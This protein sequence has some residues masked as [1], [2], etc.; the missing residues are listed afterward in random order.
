MYSTNLFQKHTFLVFCCW[1]FHIYERKHNHSDYADGLRGWN[2]HPIGLV[3]LTWERSVCFGM[4]SLKNC[5]KGKTSVNSFH[6]PA[7]CRRR[8]LFASENIKFGTFCAS[9][10]SSQGTSGLLTMERA[11][12][13]ISFGRGNCAQHT[14]VA[15]LC[16]AK[17]FR[18]AAVMRCISM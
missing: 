7:A 6:F 1:T 9:S 11:R 5:C 16:G 13:N 8:L 3:S 17:R 12:G 14:L 15:D 4:Y 2:K 10:L 18:R